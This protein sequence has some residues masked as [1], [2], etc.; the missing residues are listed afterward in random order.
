MNNINTVLFDLDGTLLDTAPDMAFALNQLRQQ[1]N[2][3]ALAYELIKPKVS[4]G[5]AA[6]LKL[7]FDIAKTDMG[8]SEI[9]QQF[10]Q[11]YRQHLTKDTQIYLGIL[12]ILEYLQKANIRWGI[13]TNK[14]GWLTEPLVEHFAFAY[15]PVCIVSGDTVQNPKPHPEPLLYA[16]Q[17]LHCEAQHCVYIGDAERDI[18]AAKQAN[19]RSLI[20]G[21][22]YIDAHDNLSAW[23]A[24]AILNTPLELIAWLK[25]VL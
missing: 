7:G 9:Y 24:E 19:M 20:A 22:G 23:G 2:L 21:Y 25:E 5:A 3:P 11:I 18:Q 13:V 10:V 15:P 16:C 12:D 4:H 17:L 8:Y 14:P 1:Y 6:L